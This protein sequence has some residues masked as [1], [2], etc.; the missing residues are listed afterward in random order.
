MDVTPIFEKRTQLW[1]LVVSLLFAA[2]G[3]QLANESGSANFPDYLAACPNTYE[4]PT[5]IQLSDCGAIADLCTDI[6]FNDLGNY[7][8]WDNGVQLSN[9]VMQACNPDTALAYNYSSLSGQGFSGPYILQNWTVNGSSFIGFFNN[10]GQLADSMNLWD[11]T[12]SWMLDATNFSIIGGNMSTNYSAIS[13]QAQ[14]NPDVETLHI[15]NFYSF[16]NIS[17][18]LDTGYHE[19]VIV[20][21]VDACRDTNYIQI[22]CS[23]CPDI[24]G[25][26]MTLDGNSCQPGGAAEF[27]LNIPADDMIFY[28]IMDNGQTYGGNLNGCNEDTTGFYF[29]LASFPN[30]DNP[31]LFTLDDWTVNGT[32]F[33]ANSLNSFA[34]LVDS[35]NVWDASGNWEYDSPVIRGGN[36]ANKYGNLLF[37]GNGPST[38]VQVPVQVRLEPQ[39]NSLEFSS[40]MHELVVV[41][42][43][44]SCADTVNLTVN[45]AN[46]CPPLVADHASSVSMDDCATAAFWCISLAPSELVNYDVEINGFNYE[47]AVTPCEF[48]TISVAYD[49]SQLQSTGRDPFRLESWLVNGQWFAGTFTDV[50]VFV[51]SVNSWHPVGNWMF[52][53]AS[54]I[55]SSN[56]IGDQLSDMEFIFQGTNDQLYVLLEEQTE[57]S[58]SSLEV[59]AGVHEIVFTDKNSGCPDTF[60]IVVDCISTESVTDT[61][62]VNDTETLCLST[63]ELLGNLMSIQNLCEGA[64]G[65]FVSIDLSSGPNCI[66]FTGV[67]VGID[68]A[69]I[70]ICDDLGL[71]DTTYIALVTIDTDNVFAAVDDSTNTLENVSIR[72]LNVIGNDIGVAMID[73]M[74]ILAPGP[75]NGMASVNP[76]YTI[77]YTPNAAYCNSTSPDQFE[78]VIC[79]NTACDTGQVSITI[80]C[81]EVKAFS[82]FSPNGDNRNDRFYIEGVETLNNSH[83]TIFNRWGNQVYEH[84]NYQNGNESWDGTFKGIDVPDGTYFYLL[85]ADSGKIY[86]GYVQLNR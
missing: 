60:N 68:S 36:P 49:L 55:L 24:L 59:F 8:V 26:P 76:D 67:E 23:N 12:A 6:P 47:D 51:D 83:L 46:N 2:P 14:S 84:A 21:N 41:N 43:S 25:P 19:F 1:L 61:V 31:G 27:C 69:C 71:C 17:V 4:G 81:D 77:S 54:G 28:Q 56:N 3:L 66:T 18:P 75:S 50:S 72:Q 40:G 38:P 30:Q 58:A 79:S 32:S 44:T 80:L 16:Q 65:E 73:T 62:E 85:E 5:T 53:D 34:Q 29:S 86:S 63:D 45:C 74:Y 57:A 82:G 42:T 39:S 52:D 10:V 13:I 7:E 35:M 33:S 78:Y 15:A 64:S 9:T 20:N 22:N 11:P 48:Q 70:K 37:A